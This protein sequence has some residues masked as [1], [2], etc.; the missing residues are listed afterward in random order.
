MFL[1]LVNYLAGNITILVRGEN[2]EDFINMAVN[3]GINIGNVYRQ[4]NGEIFLQVRLDSVKNLRPIARKTGC[5]FEIYEREGLPFLLVRI[6]RR[7]LLILGCLIFLI[8]FYVL[9][10]FIWFIDVTGNSYISSADLLTIAER[11]GLKR[12][13]L[14]WE[15]NPGLIEKS[16]KEQ[17]PAVSWVGVYIKG[18]RAR[19]EVVE[20]TQIKERNN[21][22][23]HVVAAKAGLIEEILVLQGHP[24]VK[25]GD[26]VV[27]G[28]VLISGIVPSPE[29]PAEAKVAE[30]KSQKPL[31]EP[32]YVCA[33]GIVRA[34][35]WY[36]GYGE[37]QTKETGNRL[38]GQI[39]TRVCMK[40]GDREIILIGPRNIRFVSY[41][42]ESS[43]K[44]VPHWRN[45]NLPVELIIVKYYEKENYTIL[46]N[47]EEARML[48]GKI[49]LTGA[50]QQLPAGALILNKRIEELVINNPED[51][52]RVRAFVETLESIGSVKPFKP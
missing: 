5:R 1:K 45:L 28:Q 40:I 39:I 2:P 21:E 37:A 7:K 13:T 51:L 20:K 34:R 16:I 35:R 36:E 44:R 15:V 46:R 17:L 11:T 42:E 32:A 6:R 31:Q 8:F 43:V 25:E 24:V 49:A 38:T 3:Q 27:E 4:K 18:T 52:V 9:S 29:Q 26:T 48:A 30:Q 23:A 10:S 33:E 47:H 41:S 12:G 22:P 14:K 50:E 19:I